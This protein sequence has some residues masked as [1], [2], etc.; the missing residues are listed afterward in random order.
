MHTV[1]SLRLTIVL[2][3]LSRAAMRA[4]TS[5]EGVYVGRIVASFGKAKL[6]VV[7]HDGREV[8]CKKAGRLERERVRLKV[9]DAVRVKYMLD[10][11]ED[12]QV[13]SIVGLDLDK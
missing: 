9:G 6:D 1:R 8:R 13:P 4:T 7:L 10:V 2:S 12:G 5:D 11:D 3:A